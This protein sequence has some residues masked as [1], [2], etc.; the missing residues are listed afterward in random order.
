MVILSENA[1]EG[2][3][4]WLS[5]K[6]VE[7]LYVKD[8]D[9]TYPAISAHAD[10]Y[11][12]R[13]G[14]DAMKFAPGEVGG[15]YPADCAFNGVSLD[16]Y[17]IHNRK[18]T[19]ERLLR[20]VTVRGLSYVHVNQGYTKCST[21]VI[22]GAAVIS[23]DES[24]IGAVSGL[25]DVEYLKITPGHILLPGLDCG[26]IGGACG[27]VG[28]Y[29]AFNGDLSRHPDFERIVSFVKSR[30]AEPVWFDGYPLTDIGSIIECEKII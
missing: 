21:A 20:E 1:C 15:K 9:I 2:L 11:Y 25:P 6:G 3:R 18:C 30:N 22:D 7:I 8:T 12:C 5:E 28:R 24:I 13:L 14:N 16:K 23:S 27:R 17:F 29:M 26:F 4:R 10:I 19:A